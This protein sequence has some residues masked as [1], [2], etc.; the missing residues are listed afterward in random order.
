MAGY[1][2]PLR[3]MRFVL[4]EVVGLSDI[5]ALPGCE[6]A[7]PDLVQAILE[8]AG[9]L[10][11][12]VIA[13]LN[14]PGDRQRC[15]LENGAVL[16]PDG[17]RQAYARFVEGGW[18]GVPFDPEHGGQGLPWV[19]A[20]A[21]YEIWLAAN[22]SFGLCPLLTQAA[23]ALLSGHGSP[24][25][26]QLFLPNMIRGRWTGTMDL[27]E[28]QAGSD[29]AA[30]NTRAVADDGHYRLTGQKI[31]ITWGEHDVAEN[32][33]HLVLA[34]IRDAPPGL[35]GISLFIVP[36]ILV[37]PDGRLEGRNDVTCVSLEDKLGIHGSP[38]CV[39]A[40]GDDAGAVGHLVG[41]ENRGVEYMFTMMN[42][43][44]TFIGLQGLAIAERAYQQARDYARGRVQGR[45]TGSDDAAPVAII[46]HPDVRRMLFTM[47]AEIAA[48]RGLVYHTAGLIDTAKRHTDA[49]HRARAQAQFELIT[50]LVKAWCTEL[51]V[52]IAS[53]GL[54]VHGGVGYIEETGA[55]QHFRDARIGP[56]YEGTNGIQ[57]AD[58][59]GRKVLRDRGA[60]V[61]ELIADMRVTV[62]ALSGDATADISG[63]L[64]AG[65][66]ALAATT[67]WLLDARANDIRDALAGAVPYLRLFGTVAGGWMM[68]RTAL[69]AERGLAADAGERRFNAARLL[70]ARFYAQH[71]APRAAAH[72]AA[73]TAGAGTLMA[74]DEDLF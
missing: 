74:L 52:D 59:V 38:T 10:A 68:A 36:K 18:N 64:S 7:T 22:M 54:Q 29:L 65:I 70:T 39:M 19:V 12:E 53:T 69:A 30:I 34:R 57:A 25:Q 31:F 3:D 41:E 47:K 51:G 71:L 44:R 37:G 13:P 40:F 9:R 49:A 46:R 17:F 55:A 1:T 66:D 48:M 20:A 42:N 62:A 61:R 23:V 43:A 73:V 28:P 11:G 21:L 50:P 72:A 14:Q 24:A 45:E 8:E 16:T 26:K 27:T 56:I 63:G 60:A 6:A 15:R 33:I 32:I 4:E 58:L 2:A 67:D 5:A 35:K